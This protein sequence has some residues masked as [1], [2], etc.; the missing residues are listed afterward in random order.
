MLIYFELPEYNR[1]M[2]F[3]AS[4][5]FVHFMPYQRWAQ[6]NMLIDRK[7]IDL[8]DEE[9]KNF[10]RWSLDQANKPY[11]I[12]DILGIVLGKLNFFKD[13]EKAFICSELA[14]RALKI[15]QASDFIT[16]KQLHQVIFR[17]E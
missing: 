4:H 14:A 13:G 5:F 15:D 12:K 7:W 16:P 8:S 1:S 3:E 11:S 10:V 6:D 17:K 2:V 9:F